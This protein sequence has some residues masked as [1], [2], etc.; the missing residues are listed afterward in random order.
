MIIADQ[1]ETKSKIYQS[2]VWYG[3]PQ[4]D[5]TEGSLKYNRIHYIHQSLNKKQER[6]NTQYNESELESIKQYIWELNSKNDMINS[7]ELCC[8]NIPNKISINEFFD[9]IKI[10]LSYINIIKVL[11][12]AIPNFYFIYLQFKNK[13]FANIFY[14]T[15]NYAKINLIEKEYY[16]F[17]EVREMRFE[18]IYKNGKK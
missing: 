3:N 8:I 18:E 6:E 12:S 11:K 15:F 7:Y 10:Y 1:I 13:E 4:I 17:V 2:K 16:I 9:S 5:L 14:N